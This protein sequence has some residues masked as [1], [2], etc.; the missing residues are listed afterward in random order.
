MRSIVCAGALVACLI[1]PSTAGASQIL[2]GR[3][4]QRP[5][6]EPHTRLWVMRPDGS[7]RRRLATPANSGGG[8][9]SR[10]GRRLAWEVDPARS[11]PTKFYL[12]DARGR[13]GRLVFKRRGAGGTRL[14][15]DARRLAVSLES[16]TEV[17]DLR[18][19]RTR[20]FRGLGAGGWA[21]DSRHMLVV[22]GPHETSCV[23]IA[24]PGQPPCPPP[25]Y[26]L[27]SLDVSSG[28]TSTL[29]TLT[30][31][32]PGPIGWSPDGSQI[33]YLQSGA[34]GQSQLYVM[35]A[36]GS[37]MRQVTNLAHG[38]NG[39]VWSPDGT[40]FAISAGGA[41]PGKGYIATMSSTGA[42]LRR[43][44]ADAY[45]LSLDDWSR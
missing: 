7:G 35:N 38:V 17:V 8:D 5:G 6:S 18:T 14:A 9:F 37:G 39:A 21:P 12:G 24:I 34:D 41:A 40:R 32:Q 11:G 3:G 10:S 1:T 44:T 25:G 2:F 27:Q 36:D 20:T 23:P 29:A 45:S 43:L 16:A 28:E 4:S 30:G 33:A 19:K 31:E 13:H 42:G 26:D 15:P 22:S